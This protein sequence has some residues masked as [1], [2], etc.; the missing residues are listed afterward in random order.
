[1]AWIDNIPAEYRTP[2]LESLPEGLQAL[3]LGNIEK[4]FGLMISTGREYSKPPDVKT[5]STS[6]INWDELEAYGF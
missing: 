3:V 2:S 1:M 6:A 4:R 5:E